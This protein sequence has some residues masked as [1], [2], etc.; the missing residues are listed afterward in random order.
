MIQDLVVDGVADPTANDCYI[1]GIIVVVNTH[2]DN[3]VG[4]Y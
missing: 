1:T 2:T 4:T 3:K